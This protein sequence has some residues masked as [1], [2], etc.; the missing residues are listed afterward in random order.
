M[1]DTEGLAPNEDVTYDPNHMLCVRVSIDDEDFETLRL[2]TRDVF[3]VFNHPCTEAYE[4]PFT[5]F[6]ASITVDD[7]PIE[8]VG[9]R[10][11]GF[12]GS[13]NSSRPSLKF[14]T[15]FFDEDARL[16]NTE[17]IT[18]NNNSGELTR[19]RT[20]VIYRI[21]ERA[22][23]P[24]PQCNLAS[25]V[26]NDRPIGV[27]THIEPV[28]KRMLRRLFG[29]DEGSL[30]E[31]TITDFRDDWLI[32]YEAKTSDSDPAKT[33][34]RQITRVLEEENDDLF[35][36]ELG[37][38]LNVDRFITFW[39]LEALVVHIDGYTGNTNNHYIYFDPDDDERAT[40]L[41]WSVDL[42]LPSEGGPFAEVG[43]QDYTRGKIASR[44]SRIPQMNE[45]F[46]TELTR[47]LDEEWN[48]DE[49][50]ADIDRSAALVRLGQD[51]PDYEAALDDFK[52]IVL[53]REAIVRR[54][55]DEGLPPRA[56]DQRT[57][58]PFGG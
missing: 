4:S 26:V 47:L 18:L 8:N 21:F 54:L 41:P 58:T 25:V 40:F 9:V 38:V 2:Q 35:L 7:V 20:C 33:P 51:A 5:W 27:Y 45:R 43:L 46:L 19:V 10:Q 48:T 30:Y 50:L 14:K 15:N 24:A 57:C 6:N 3:S 32:R 55:I 42:A 52:A 1:L 22:G 49:I 23:Y 13:L 37:R 44:F 53:E 28:K 16:G 36:F 31:G 39:A 11:K 29:N 12:A 34:L 56:Q 17:R